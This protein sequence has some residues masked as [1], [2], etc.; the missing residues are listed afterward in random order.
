MTNN[1]DFIQYSWEKIMLENG[2]QSINE[3]ELWDWIKT[4]DQ[5][6]M[7]SV[8]PNLILIIEKMQSLP[9]P[10]NHS[11]ASFGHSMRVLQYIAKEGLERFRKDI[12][13]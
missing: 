2:Y 7:C 3:L 8:H 10:P 9:N 11:G 13:E 6:F 4:Y 1:F 5:R 12:E